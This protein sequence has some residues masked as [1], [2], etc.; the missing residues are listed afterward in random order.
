MFDL[1]MVRKPCKVTTSDTI[2]Q[3]IWWFC[4][5]CFCD[6]PC[7]CEWSYQKPYFLGFLVLFWGP[8]WASKSMKSSNIRKDIQQNQQKQ[9]VRSL[10]NTT[11]FLKS[12][13]G[14]AQIAWVFATSANLMHQK[15][16]F[17]LILMHP[18][19]KNTVVICILQKWMIQKPLYFST[20][21]RAIINITMV[22]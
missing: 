10:K 2:W 13:T 1:Q 15:P 20:L 12:S 5:A 17:F 18:S 14:S 3:N 16:V 6:F 9:K 4:K 11:S 8:V 21:A 22:S 19:S 7:F